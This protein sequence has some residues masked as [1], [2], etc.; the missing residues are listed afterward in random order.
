MNDQNNITN[1]IYNELNPT[2]EAYYYKNIF[3]K[4]FGSH[5]Y[6]IIPHYWQPKWIDQTNKYIDRTARTLSV[7][8]H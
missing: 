1:Y 3:K 2:I 4:Y 5:R 7:N 8:H 6:T